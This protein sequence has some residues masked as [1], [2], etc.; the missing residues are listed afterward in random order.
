MPGSFPPVQ[1]EINVEVADAADGC[2]VF[3][4]LHEFQND[5]F[6]VARR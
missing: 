3:H 5:D 4:L 6:E 1:Y 2:I